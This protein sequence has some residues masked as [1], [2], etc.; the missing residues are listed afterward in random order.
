VSDIKSAIQ[1][2]VTALSVPTISYTVD[3]ERMTITPSGSSTAGGTGSLEC[4]AMITTNPLPDNVPSPAVQWFFGPNNSSLLPSGVITTPGSS[5]ILRFSPLSHSHAGMYTCR[6]AGSVRLAAH[7]TLIV[8][9]M[10]FYK[11][12]VSVIVFCC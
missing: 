2:T 12:K 6:L 3:I 4:S 11:F 5:N 7:T 9:G 8:N 1:T 10:Y